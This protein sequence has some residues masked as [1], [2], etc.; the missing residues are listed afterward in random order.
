MQA[1]V[2]A[3]TSSLCMCTVPN[4]CRAKSCS[5]DLDV[6]THACVS[7]TVQGRHCAPLASK[8]RGRSSRALGN[9]RANGQVAGAMGGHMDCSGRFEHAAHCGFLH[10]SIASLTCERI[11][12]ILGSVAPLWALHPASPSRRLET[13]SPK[14]DSTHNQPFPQRPAP[15]LHHR[16][17][18]YLA[19][20]FPSLNPYVTHR[21]V[22]REARGL[23]RA[24]RVG[25]N[26]QELE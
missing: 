13:G 9:P 1:R 22:E 17:P 16:L 11:G 2:K 24:A 5:P 10:E 7:D 15:S 20:S 26:G 23:S 25:A 12:K 14:P 19:A 18:L 4:W 8:R 6:Y 21:L 3:Q